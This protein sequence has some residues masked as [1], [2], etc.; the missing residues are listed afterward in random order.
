MTLS[1]LIKSH[2]DRVAEV[3]RPAAREELLS[4]GYNHTVALMVSVLVDEAGREKHVPQIEASILAERFKQNTRDIARSMSVP[5]K[6]LEIAE[7][8]KAN[9]IGYHGRMR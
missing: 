1:Q 8:N 9:A 6:M 2:C 4:A 3:G 7:P 5:L